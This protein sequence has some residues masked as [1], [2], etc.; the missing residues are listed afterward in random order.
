M[1]SMTD[2]PVT[3]K[4]EVYQ[5]TVFLL[6]GK[7]TLNKTNHGSKRGHSCTAMMMK[8]ARTVVLTRKQGD[9]GEILSLAGIAPTLSGKTTAVICL[10][11]MRKFR[12]IKTSTVRTTTILVGNMYVYQRFMLCE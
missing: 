2:P 5:P 9:Q 6:R 12:M 4:G 7:S 8:R 1:I 11:K 3:I 10:L